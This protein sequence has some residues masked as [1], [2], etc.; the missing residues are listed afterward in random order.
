MRR[1]DLMRQSILWQEAR[2][3]N[4][5]DKKAR[6]DAFSLAKDTYS[7]SEYSIH[8]FAGKIPRWS[9]SLGKSDEELYDKAGDVVL[10]GQTL[11]R[12][13][14]SCTTSIRTPWI[15][16]WGGSASLQFLDL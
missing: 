6:T 5:K 3:I 15:Y 1:L 12:A 14:E 11:G 8:A 10:S 2:K 4:V 13:P 9:C 7:F 16:P